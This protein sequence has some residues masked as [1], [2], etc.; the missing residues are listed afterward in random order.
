MTA[1]SDTASSPAIRS[2][3]PA[4]IDAQI[5]ASPAVSRAGAQL[6]TSSKAGWL[7]DGGRP[8]GW[9]AGWRA[10][11]GA[12]RPRQAGGRTGGGGPTGRDRPTGWLGRSTGWLGPIGRYRRAS[13][14]G[15]LR[16]SH[17]A[18]RSN[19]SPTPTSTMRVQAPPRILARWAM[20]ARDR[21][22]HR[23]ATGTS[24]ARSP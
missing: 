10:A 17:T 20:V 15:W 1:T 19:R 7:A 23:L 6:A 8:T 2:L 4:R 24:R 11:A 9:R 5:A 12:G 22:S 16:S 14:S 13:I 21:L 3:I 18:E